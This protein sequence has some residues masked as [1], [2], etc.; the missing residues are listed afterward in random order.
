ME[1]DKLGTR[2]DTTET[3]KYMESAMKMGFGVPAYAPFAGASIGYLLL[4]DMSEA[5][6]VDLIFKYDGEEG[7]LQEFR[8]GTVLYYVLAESIHVGVLPSRHSFWN[9]TSSTGMTAL[10]SRAFF[11]LK[12]RSISFKSF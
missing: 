8:H 7:P 6:L 12:S 4:E 9:L 10:F 3:P 1:I 2:R 5:N 11:I